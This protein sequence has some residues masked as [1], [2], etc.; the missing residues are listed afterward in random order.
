MA[1]HA[2][3]AVAQAQQCSP[4]LQGHSGGA[5][6]DALAGMPSAQQPPLYPLPNVAQQLPLCSLP[7]D[8]QQP[9]LYPLTGGSQQFPL[10]PLPVVGDAPMLTDDNLNQ[11][12]SES[13][14]SA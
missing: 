7:D 14:N 3:K 5:H 4:S 8:A 9:P 10:Y 11:W 12:L 6:V 2:E 1:C 13:F